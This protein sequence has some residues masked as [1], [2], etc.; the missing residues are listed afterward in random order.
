MMR[1]VKA[2]VCWAMWASLV[3][4]CKGGR[5]PTAHTRNGT[6]AGVHSMQ[7]D[8]DFFLGVPY[9]QPPIQ[10]LRFRVPE[11]L[12]E[13]WNGSRSAT[14]YSPGCIGY[15]DDG[16][17]L[18]RTVMSEDCLYLNI[19]RPSGLLPHTR[20]PVAGSVDQSSPSSSSIGC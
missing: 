6:Y 4:P 20:I 19:V 7:H 9:A 5:V 3:L 2:R 15:G 16:L 1:G 12:N 14:T 18:D 8:Q 17:A 13:V 10:D 11:P